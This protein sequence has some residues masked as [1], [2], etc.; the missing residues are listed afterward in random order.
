MIK[1]EEKSYLLREMGAEVTKMGGGRMGGTPLFEV[2][3][4]NYVFAPPPTLL[5]EK[6]ECL[7]W[8]QKLFNKARDTRVLRVFF[9]VK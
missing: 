8:K 3:V 2:W 5:L 1:G 9:T 4:D 6:A 7:A